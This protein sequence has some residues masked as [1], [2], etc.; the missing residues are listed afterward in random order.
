M[1]V[2]MSVCAPVPHK[3]VEGCIVKEN[4]G[5]IPAASPVH[6]SMF[7]AE[8]HNACIDV[9]LMPM[10]CVSVHVSVCACVCV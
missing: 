3:M 1:S 10:V 7:T 5:R 4:S 9:Y 8:R 2:Q 6:V